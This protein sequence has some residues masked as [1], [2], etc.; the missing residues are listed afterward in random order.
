[1]RSRG[2][3]RNDDV[4]A[5]HTPEQTPQRG[6]R[7]HRY[8]SKRPAADI[9]SLL[10][11]DGGVVTDGEYTSASK[12]PRISARE[13]VRNEFRKQP[14]QFRSYARA[15]DITVDMD[16]MAR[17]FQIMRDR[18][19]SGST[20][21]GSSSAITNGSGNDVVANNV[22]GGDDGASIVA[23]LLDG[24]LLRNDACGPSVRPQSRAKTPRNTTNHKLAG[25]W[26]IDFARDCGW[27]NNCRIVPSSTPCDAARSD[28]P[29]VVWAGSGT[30]LDQ[31]M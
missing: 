16:R 25:R 12:R 1:M 18:L 28:R 31:S 20:G 8:T 5:G 13:R 17:D 30:A 6:R 29:S 15:N 7:I 9:R 10:T 14:L 26:V 27:H 23:T 22:R 24:P 21:C 4:R 3:V 2:G 19:E 11:S